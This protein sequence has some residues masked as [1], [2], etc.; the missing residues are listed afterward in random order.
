[1]AREDVSI[2]GIVY[3]GYSKEDTTDWSAGINEL[4]K[5]MNVTPVST[6]GVSAG[7][8]FIFKYSW[9]ASGNHVVSLTA[10]SNTRGL[11]FTIYVSGTGTVWAW[12][13][14]GANEDMNTP[15]WS[16]RTSGD[17]WKTGTTGISTTASSISIAKIPMEALGRSSGLKVTAIYMIDDESGGAPFI[18]PNNLTSAFTPFRSTLSGVPESTS[19]KLNVF[20]P[21]HA[22]TLAG[23]YNGVAVMPTQ[24]TQPMPPGDYQCTVPKGYIN[25][26]G[27]MPGQNGYARLFLNADPNASTYSED[28]EE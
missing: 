17:V 24:T 4:Q 23:Y 13:G 25:L 16:G 2:G 8:E 19:A 28:D 10:S 6:S 7:L 18:F 27:V 5:R 22:P 20:G 9:M 3:Y 11:A 21:I 12:I 1:M 26:K 14:I 15:R